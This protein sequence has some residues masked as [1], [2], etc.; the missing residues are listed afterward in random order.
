MSQAWQFWTGNAI[1]PTEEHY[2]RVIE[3]NQQEEARLA[4]HEEELKIVGR[5]LGEK[6][7]LKFIG[8]S[9]QYPP[10]T[11]IPRDPRRMCLVPPKSVIKL[12][13]EVASGVADDPVDSASISANASRERPSS[14]MAVTSPMT[15]ASMTTG[16]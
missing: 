1:N 3:Q 13:F 14:A 16:I 11:S 15:D 12:G 8:T 7:G 2:R 4:A 6:H 5:E 10:G 9:R